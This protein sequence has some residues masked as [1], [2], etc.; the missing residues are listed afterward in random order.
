[1]LCFCYQLLYLPC[2]YQDSS[3]SS[4]ATQVACSK[5]KAD[6]CQPAGES[7]SKRKRKTGVKGSRSTPNS[8]ERCCRKRIS[9]HQRS[10]VY[11]C[12]ANHDSQGY[13]TYLL[14]P[15]LRESVPIQEV[16]DHFQRLGEH[17]IGICLHI[18]I[19]T[20]RR[21]DRSS[22]KTHRQ[23]RGEISEME[24]G[25]DL[26]FFS[27]TVSIQELWPRIFL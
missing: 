10:R 4:I 24:E 14:H 22:N 25:V 27:L 8:S 6:D 16:F 19:A 5:A 18:F 17:L 11:E 21:K 12:L 2:F 20:T 15:F 26:A 1:M 3:A 9:H 13:Y 23:K 7:D